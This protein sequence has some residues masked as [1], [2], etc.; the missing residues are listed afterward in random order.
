MKKKMTRFFFLKTTS[1]EKNFL[2]SSILVSNMGEWKASAASVLNEIVDSEAAFVV[3]LRLLQAEFVEPL[4]RAPSAPLSAAASSKIFMNSEPILEASEAYLARLRAEVLRTPPADASSAPPAA[5]SAGGG[6]DVARADVDGSPGGWVGALRRFVPVFE[7]QLPMLFVYSDYCTRYPIALEELAAVT[8]AP[9]VRAVVRRAEARPAVARRSLEDFLIMPIQRICKYPLLL[10]DLVR[11]VPDAA[12]D[13]AAA[14]RGRLEKMARTTEAIA[15]K[16]NVSRATAANIQRLLALSTKIG[17]LPKDFKLAVPTRTFVQSGHVLERR[18]D[19][20]SAHATK[21]RETAAGAGAGAGGGGGSSVAHVKLF[22]FTDVLIVAERSTATS[23]FR[24]REDSGGQ[25]VRRGSVRSKAAASSAEPAGPPAAGTGAAAGAPGPAGAAAAA[26][27]KY[28]M[29]QLF[30]VATTVAQPVP[31]EM[32]GNA[33]H[34]FKLQDASSKAT[35]WLVAPSAQAQADWV[36]AIEVARDGGAA[37]STYEPREFVAAGAQ[38]SAVPAPPQSLAPGTIE[39]ELAALR[40]E[41]AQ[42]RQRREELETIVLALVADVT[43]LKVD[44]SRLRDGPDAQSAPGDRHRSVDATTDAPQSSPT[45]L[46]RQPLSRA[47]GSVDVVGTM[48]VS[49]DDDAGRKLR[50]FYQTYGGQDA[51]RPVKKA[52]SPGPTAAPADGTSGAAQRGDT[53]VELTSYLKKDKVTR[54]MKRK[55]RSRSTRERQEAAT[56][57]A[58]A[59]LPKISSDDGASL[60][61]PLDGSP[62]PA[63]RAG[64][65]SSQPPPQSSSLPQLTASSASRSRSSSESDPSSLGSILE[66]FASDSGGWVI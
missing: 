52:A 41:L 45:V 23:D 11:R 10:K 1:Q 17:G 14:L 12:S 25:R 36:R 26:A 18:E 64:P 4:A 20:F 35:A 7:D 54:E 44:A 34:A 22:L 39:E 43:K 3:N 31:P 29:T 38:H 66:F 6:A 28:T 5:G 33:L 61:S 47:S 40:S 51:L 2:N 65:P 63:R 27:R 32:A 55:S 37:A 30:R 8:R 21:S 16:I 19:S 48:L 60:G 57:A 62:S 15:S 42:E 13:D 59:H 9:D 49:D 46:R 58:D 24:G 56:L 53:A 50:E